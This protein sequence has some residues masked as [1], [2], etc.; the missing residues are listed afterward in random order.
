MQLEE[1][2]RTMSAPKPCRVEDCDR[3][4]TH[5]TLCSRHQHRLA[6]YG[7]LDVDRSA[8]N[9]GWVS[10]NG[11]PNLAA[12]GHPLRRQNRVAVGRL[13]LYEKIGPGTH[14]CTWCDRPLEWG[15]NLRAARVNGDRADSSPENLVAACASCILERSRR[16]ET[17][18]KE[19]VVPAPQASSQLQS[20]TSS[21]LA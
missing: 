7:D 10:S 6:R 14:P 9:E 3:V 5:G 16:G 8:P 13:V 15:A 21:D 17:R 1:R 20:A 19:H 11:Y 4:T 2:C 18:M 12:H